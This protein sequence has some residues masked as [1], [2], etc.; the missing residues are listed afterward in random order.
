MPL[1]QFA[2][3]AR[4]RPPIAARLD[5]D[6]EHVT[7]LVNGAPQIV[8]PSLHRYKELVQIPRVAQAASPA[9]QPPSVV[10]PERLTPVPNRFIGH[11]DTP[12]REGAS[13]INCWRP[14]G[15][16]SAC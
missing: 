16:P 12:F 8:V 15:N 7:V 6:V 14:A 1:Q 3:K 4:G 9:P 5:Q 13:A 11:G 10:E 2:E